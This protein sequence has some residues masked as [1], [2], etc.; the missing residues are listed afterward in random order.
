VKH[1]HTERHHLALQRFAELELEVMRAFSV[2]MAKLDTRGGAEELDLGP[3][4]AVSGG[5]YAPPI[6]ILACTDNRGAVDARDV[7]RACAFFQQR[8]MRAEAWVYRGLDDDFAAL[9]EQGGW[10]EEDP[11]QISRMVLDGTEKQAEPAG[12]HRARLI[13]SDEMGN[14]LKSAAQCWLKKESLDDSDYLIGTAFSRI[15]FGRFLGVRQDGQ[16]V[17]TGLL[18]THGTSASLHGACTLPWMRGRGVQQALI[19]GRIDLARE[20]GCSEVFVAG[21]PGTATLRNSLRL[22]FAELGT[23]RV[24]RMPKC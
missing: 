5:R 11:H 15:P 4:M 7:E 9:L 12:D 17:G 14:A 2:E 20:T 24:Y 1:E 19:A 13:G 16:I 22:G 18:F 21:L 8:G 6:Q 3:C 23:R 10:V